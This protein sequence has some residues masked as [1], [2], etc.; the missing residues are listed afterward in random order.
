MECS[1]KWE[2]ELIFLQ[3]Q[4]GRSIF[5]WKFRLSNQLDS[6]KSKPLVP[7]TI[8]LLGHQWLC[9]GDLLTK[10]KG[11][12]TIRQISWPMTC[13]KLMFHH[14]LPKLKKQRRDDPVSGFLG[15]VFF[16]LFFPLCQVLGPHVG[17]AE[18][19]RAT[20]CLRSGLSDS[21]WGAPVE[22]WGSKK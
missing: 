16:F 1:P 15:D 21:S 3:H 18:L 19:S 7:S 17:P 4:I 8:V 13:L 2:S 12:G 11:P 10:S 22:F 20:S 5:G 6:Y 9:L 14:I